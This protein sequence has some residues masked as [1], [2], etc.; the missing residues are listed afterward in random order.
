MN[1]VRAGIVSHPGDYP[2]SSYQH[3]VYGIP[4]QLISEHSL[5]QE[6]GSDPELRRASYQELFVTDM[7]EK[8]LSNIRKAIN[9]STPLGNDRFRDEINQ[10]ITD[11]VENDKRAQ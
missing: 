7:D 3:N 10:A 2:W 4:N 8:M 9:F 5:Y 11:K 6:L 1:P